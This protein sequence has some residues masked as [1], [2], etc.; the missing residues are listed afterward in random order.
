M[1]QCFI[2][3]DSAD[4]MLTRLYATFKAAN[5]EMLAQKRVLIS[6]G[7]KLTRDGKEQGEWRCMRFSKKTEDGMY[8]YRYISFKKMDIRE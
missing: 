2:Y 7:Y 3:T 4:G 1:E 6:Y 5:R 8:A